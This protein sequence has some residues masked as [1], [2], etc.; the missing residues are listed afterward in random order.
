MDLSISV[1]KKLF[2]DYEVYIKSTN[3]SGDPDFVMDAIGAIKKY[4]TEAVTGEKLIPLVDTLQ[5][6]LQ[7]LE[8]YIEIHSLE[9]D[10]NANCAYRALEAVIETFFFLS[11][12]EP[13]CVC[14]AVSNLLINTYQKV[15]N[16]KALTR[17]EAVNHPSVQAVMTFLLSSV[18]QH[19]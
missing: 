9:D 8:I 2:F 17:A 19:A 18:P 16:N 5:L 10:V 3:C 1:C 4:N 11:M 14:N 12:G 7:N 13:E 6:Y 15:Q